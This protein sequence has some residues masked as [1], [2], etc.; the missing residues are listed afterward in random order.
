VAPP[1]TLAP[2]DLLRR[3]VA[4]DSTSSRTN[5][6]VLEL[7]EEALSRSP[8]SVA[9]APRLHRVTTD[10][11]DKANLVAFFGPRTEAADRGGL[12]LSGHTDVVPALEPDWDSPPFAMD[13]RAGN[14]YGRGTADMKGF[15]ALATHLAA[16]VDPATL[17]APLVLLFTHDE[18][19]GTL[20]AQRLAE[21]WRDGGPEP[22]PR[23]CVIG[24]PTSLRVIRFHKGHLK[25]RVQAKGRPAHSSLP[26]LG[27]NAI[28]AMGRAI[29]A[30]TELRRE[31]EGERSETSLYFPEAPFVPLNLG[32]VSGG[33]AINVVPEACSLDVGIRLL[34]AP[35]RDSS[36]GSRA[37]RDRVERAVRS[38]AKG[39]DEFVVSVL[40]DSPPLSCSHQSSIA[41]GFVAE[42]NDAGERGAPYA[43]DGGPLQA[44][45]IESVL[46]GPGSI[47]V[48]HRA[49][50]FLPR[51]EF[52]AAAPVLERL[53]DRF[54]R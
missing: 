34:P 2:D 20:G 4:I 52:E 5:L 10:E 16:R 1:T 28:E 7:I 24:E 44:L 31:L 27:K 11:G 8:R 43:S 51:A 47:E 54:C 30:L 21:I 33:V 14:W 38:S 12:I 37:V 42:L 15:L 53:V 39:D 18:E 17:R 32:M 35:G 40:G 6:P 23:A 48:A 46:W 41:R 36:E 45:G 50:E 13:E 22:L 3:L 19:V 26:H 9:G 29:A 25:L 49:N